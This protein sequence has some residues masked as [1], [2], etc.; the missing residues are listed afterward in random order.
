VI[1]WLPIERV[2]VALLVALPLERATG[3]PKFVPPTWNCTVPPSGIG[4]TLAV[5]VTDCPY[6]EGFWD[7]VTDVEVDAW[8]TVWPP[9][10]VPVLVG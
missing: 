1:V 7:E 9:E 3:L 6:V 8:F 5:K 2:V 4:L 10:S